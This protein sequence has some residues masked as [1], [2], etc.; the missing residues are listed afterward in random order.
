MAQ[1]TITINGREYAIA[2]GAGEESHILR[3]ARLVD[4]KSKLLTSSG[5][6]INENQLLAM[7]SLLLADELEDAKKG[8]AAP[9]VQIK[10][11]EK[12]VEKI[13]ETEPDCTAV[14]IKLAESVKNVTNQIKTLA[15]ELEKL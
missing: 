7:T 6:H 15:T 8:I 4:E 12:V 3:L 1:I 14:D 9:E 2:C 10:T 11:V 5:Q 13:I